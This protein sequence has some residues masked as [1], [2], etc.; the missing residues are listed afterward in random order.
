MGGELGMQFPSREDSVRLGFGDLRC[1][2]SQEVDPALQP[3]AVDDQLQQVAVPDSSD[4][5]PGQRLRTDMA[6]AGTGGHPREAGVGD[7]RN[8]LAPGDELEGRGDLV[9]LLHAGA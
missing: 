8:G 6:D 7:D 1:A 4:G 9:D 2:G 3:A 5:S